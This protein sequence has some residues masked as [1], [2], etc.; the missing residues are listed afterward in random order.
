MTRITKHL[1]NLQNRIST[2]CARDGQNRNENGRLSFGGQQTPWR[3]TAVQEALCDAG[4][5]CHGRELPAGSPGENPCSAPPTSPG[6][7]SAASS[8]TKPGQIAEHFQLGAY[9][10]KRSKAARRLSEQRPCRT[11]ALLIYVY[12]SIRRRRDSDHG[13]VA[14]R[15]QPAELCRLKSRSYSQRLRLRGL[16]TIPLP[17]DTI[18][19]GQRAPFRPP[20][21]TL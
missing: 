21:R 5:T 13:G 11:P 6:T 4:L 3:P 17:A 18:E 9:G 20:A 8:P 7:T 16:M 10:C 14:I 12:R 1:V 19:A 2:A 15:P